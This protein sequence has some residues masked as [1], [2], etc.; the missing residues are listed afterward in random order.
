M[1][2]ALAIG[3]GMAAP[4]DAQQTSSRRNT[5]NEKVARASWRPVQAATAPQLDDDED[6]DLAPRKAKGRVSVIRQASGYHEAPAVP[7]SN[8]TVM[9]QP[10]VQDSY[11]MDGQ[12][13]L[14]P[15][16]DGSIACD[17]LP[18]GSCGCADASCDGIGCDAIGSCNSCGPAGCGELIGGNAWRPCA[19]LCLPTDGWFSAEYLGWTQDGMYL[20]P[21]VTS[22]VGTGIA[23]ADAGILGRA[24]T[25]TLFGGN[26]ILD[27]GFNGAR[28]RFGVWLDRCHK[29]GVGGELFRIGEETES[30]SRTSTGDPILARPFFNTTTGL[31]DSELV[32]FP[33]VVSGTVAVNAA[34]ELQGWGVHV[35]RLG[36][37]DQGCTNGFFCG[38]PSHFCRRTEGLL[39]IRGLQLDERVGIRENLVGTAGEQFVINDNFSTRNQFTGIDLGWRQRNVR[40]FWTMD[41]G[42]RIALGTTSQSV[43]ING[44]TVITDPNGVPNTPQTFNGGLLAQRTNSGTFKRDD[45]SVVPEL[46][47]TLGYQLTDNLRLTLGYTFLYW[48]SVVRPGQHIPTDLNPNLLPPETDPFTGA[49]RPAFAFDTTDYWAQGINVGGEYR[50]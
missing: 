3:L 5:A 12:I 11:P 15:V 29:F 50:W 18:G 44:D 37:T 31:N 9:D 28:L 10:I 16:M 14:G 2:L 30:F 36:C 42:V 27:D 20:P 1:T 7:A 48:S 34:S 43:T 22:N 4:A 47:A 8:A 21:L 35:R 38:C 39:G 13:V 41:F 33:G 40:G 45:F 25:V 23:R 26:E 32:A 24:S 17:G 46:E 6:A 19:T 49:L